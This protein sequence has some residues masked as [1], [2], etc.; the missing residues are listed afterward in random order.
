MN[1][2]H[3]MTDVTDNLSQDQQKRNSAQQLLTQKLLTKART[4]AGISFAQFADLRGTALPDNNISSKGWFGQQAEI[5]LGATAKSR[6]E[7]DFVELGIELKTLPLTQNNQPKEST[8]VCTVPA[9]IMGQ[10]WQDCWL[11]RKLAHVLWLPYEADSKLNRA[12]RRIGTAILWHPSSAQQAALQRD[13]EE[14]MAGLSL[15]EMAQIS[16]HQGQY[17]QIR[18]KA[19]NSRELTGMVNDEG[20]TAPN[21]PCGFYLRP[22]FTRQIL[23]QQ[24]E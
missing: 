24:Y 9:E 19:A 6:A 11:R 2:T 23:Q 7:P 17:L 13:W 12:D 14:L 22:S 16:S 20:A 18:P 5:Y 1:T 15:G 10:H 3:N 4:L 8:Y 21:L